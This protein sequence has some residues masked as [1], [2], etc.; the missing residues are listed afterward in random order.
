MTSFTQQI[1]ESLHGILFKGAVGPGLKG[2]TKGDAPWTGAIMTTL[3][4][5][6][7]AHGF[8]PRYKG[9]AGV[10]GEWLWDHIWLEMNE[11]GDIVDVPMTAE[12]ELDTSS[13]RFNARQRP[14]F[15][16]LLATRSHQRLFIYQLPERFNPKVEGDNLDHL[17]NLVRQF[18]WAA[19][20]E[21]FLI[22]ALQYRADPKYL[23]YRELVC[24]HS[25]WQL[26]DGQYNCS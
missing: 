20:G 15:N 18:P 1:L 22:V 24:V 4:A 12:C 9:E 3:A 7:T 16:K 21:V 23:K 26:T 25:G 14:D 17:T 6:G 2:E 10:G 11:R 19:I 8:I 5:R 13:G